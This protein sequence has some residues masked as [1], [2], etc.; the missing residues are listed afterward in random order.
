MPEQMTVFE[1]AGAIRSGRFLP[2]DAV[3][4]AYGSPS[5]LARGIRRVQRR[6]LTDL[7]AGSDDPEAIAEVAEAYCGYTHAGMI[8]DCLDTLEMTSPRARRAAWTEC[9]QPGTSI[10]VVRP[11][12]PA[13]AA[14]QFAPVGLDWAIRAKSLRHAVR[15]MDEQV[16]TAYPW[17]ELLTYWFSSLPGAIAAPHFAEHFRDHRRNVCSGAVWAAWVSAGAVTPASWQDAMPESWYPARMA[18]DREYLE[19]VACMTCTEDCRGCTPAP[20]EQASKEKG[21]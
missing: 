15:T 17:R 4:Y 19:C 1:F 5:V 6:A 11:R 2:G 10:L 14:P 20:L 8:E 3:C 13:L 18:M 9:L 12:L 16:G 7:L 21:R